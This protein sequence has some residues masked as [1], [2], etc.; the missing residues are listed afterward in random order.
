MKSQD[1]KPKLKEGQLYAELFGE[2][3]MDIRKFPQ[4]EL[5][6]FY[7]SKKILEPNP[8][9]PAKLRFSFKEIAKVCSDDGELNPATMPQVKKMVAQMKLAHKIFHIVPEWERDVVEEEA[10]LQK[11]FAERRRKIV[12]YKK[13]KRRGSK[14]MSVKLSDLR[15]DSRKINGEIKFKQFQVEKGK[16]QLPAKEIEAVSYVYHGALQGTLILMTKLLTSL[17]LEQVKFETR[18]P[19][20]VSELAILLD[21]LVNGRE[22]K[23]LYAGDK[24]SK[25][26]FD[27][28][29]EVYQLIIDGLD[30]VRVKV[31]EPARKAILTT[32]SLVNRYYDE[33]TGRDIQDFGQGISQKYL[34]TASKNILKSKNPLVKKI[35]PNEEMVERWLED[36]LS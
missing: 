14:D 29:R 21:D 17:R 16:E 26:E 30:S 9:N 1:S 8:V 19:T 13:V 15:N 7:F 2:L 32:S 24:F 33:N 25:E 6:M 27:A 23:N 4:S 3:V 36:N 18:F 22:N 10:E 11:L 28:V 34:R 20:S 35:F 31:S 12:E 5:G